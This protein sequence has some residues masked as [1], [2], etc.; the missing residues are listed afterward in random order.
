MVLYINLEE[1]KARESVCVPLS[2]SLEMRPV[3]SRRY[4]V[5]LSNLVIKT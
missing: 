2:G 1:S 3:E 4:W 5:A